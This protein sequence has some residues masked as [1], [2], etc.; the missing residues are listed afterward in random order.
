MKEGFQK[1]LKTI[2]FISLIGF[3]LVFAAAL[4][5]YYQEESFQA[6]SDLKYIAPPIDQ[7]FFVEKWVPKSFV[8][9][10]IMSKRI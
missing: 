1:I 10:T 4:L 9:A 6:E 7:S 8:P 2:L 3:C 5:A